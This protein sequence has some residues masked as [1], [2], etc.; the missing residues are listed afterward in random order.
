MN[1]VIP[2]DQ[3]SA[4][5]NARSNIAV[6][7]TG[8]NSAL[9]LNEEK[10]KWKMEMV[11]LHEAEV[12]IDYN[13][14]RMPNKKAKITITSE[15]TKKTEESKNTLTIGDDTPTNNM[16]MSPSSFLNGQRKIK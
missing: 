14:V 1:T 9:K 15:G 10:N 8:T 5:K 6:A 3:Y 16:L 12:K 7:D 4:Y 13:A 11:K 2:L